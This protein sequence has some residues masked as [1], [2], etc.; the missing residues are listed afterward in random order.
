MSRERGSSGDRKKDR[1][2]EYLAQNAA[3]YFEQNIAEKKIFDKWSILDFLST[4][5]C[6]KLIFFNPFLCKIMSP[7]EQE[8]EEG[9]EQEQEPIIR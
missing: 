2:G 4:I 7:L 6:S 3:M 9:G 1:Q 5:F 8:V